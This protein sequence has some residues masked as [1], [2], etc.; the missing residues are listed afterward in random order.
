MNPECWL[1]CL[2]VKLDRL[3]T[4]AMARKTYD[5]NGKRL[6]KV[7]HYTPSFKLRDLGL[8]DVDYNDPEWLLVSKNNEDQ[9]FF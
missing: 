4:I 9:P 2:L 5:K 3:Y 7:K 1:K 8:L 6:Y